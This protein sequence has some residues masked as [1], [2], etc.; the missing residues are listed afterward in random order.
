MHW[1]WEEICHNRFVQC[2]LTF[3]V[4]FLFS[5]SHK[6][7]IIVHLIGLFNIFFFF[8][9]TTMYL[10]FVIYFIKFSFWI[11][12]IS[13][14]SLFKKFIT[15]DLY[16]ICFI[17]TLSFLFNILWIISSLIY[18]ISFQHKS[19]Y[20]SITLIAFKIHAISELLCQYYLISLILIVA[21]TVTVTE[22]TLF[23]QFGMFI[24]RT[25]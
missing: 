9:L 19:L 4:H 5:L 24:T 1:K 12:L 22:T 25:H 10:F 3:V 17:Y 18:N 6:S 2:A 11:Y 20:L 23:Y 15:I 14:E 16:L 21:T 13:F 7:H 8:K